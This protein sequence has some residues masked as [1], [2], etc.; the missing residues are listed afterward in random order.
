MWLWAS[1]RQLLCNVYP[2]D[3]A[4][5]GRS[6]RHRTTLLFALTSPQAPPTKCERPSNVRY[7]RQ[8]G[9]NT[10]RLTSSQSD[11]IPD[12]L[13]LDR[14]APRPAHSIT[15]STRLSRTVDTSRPIAFA[16]SRLAISS[17]FVG[18][19]TGISPDSGHGMDRPLRARCRFTLFGLSFHLQSHRHY[20]Y[21]RR[22]STSLQSASDPILITYLADLSVQKVDLKHLF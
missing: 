18:C 10:L 16:V 2:L 14:Q 5:P 17:N 20:S 9:R 3:G 6:C 8:R 12:L 11:P 21:T 4:S 7:R 19:S 1:P 22:S 15:W 13:S